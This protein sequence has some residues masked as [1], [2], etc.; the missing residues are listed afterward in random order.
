MNIAITGRHLEITQSLREY[1]LK[2]IEKLEKYFH[3]LI[4]AHII[5]YIEK[6]DHVVEI[7]INGD[8]VRFHAVEKAGDMYSSIDL[9]YDKIEKQVIKYKDKHSGHKATPLG[10]IG[11]LDMV[12]D[13]GVELILNQVSNKPLNPVEA[14]LAMKV[15]NADFILFK[16]GIDNVKSDMNYFNRN[17]AVIYRIDSGLRL[18]EIP[19]E[20]IKRN[21]FNP[22][23]FVEYELRILNE[24]PTK[25]RIKLKKSRGADVCCATINEA[26]KLISETEKSFLLFFN[27]ESNYFNIIYR[28]G[29]NYEVMVPTY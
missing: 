3:Q 22:D 16:K 17:Y 11:T 9:L 24:S 8:G 25:P 10:E 2:K 12:S 26:I 1:A 21:K 27:T 19:D 28:N 5:M 23:K 14:F 6:V 4:D 7:L 29:R 18:I 20:M 13:A 15:D